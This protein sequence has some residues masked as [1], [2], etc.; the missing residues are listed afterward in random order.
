MGT[1][2]TFWLIP[3]CLLLCSGSGIIGL[4]SPSLFLRVPFLQMN[5]GYRSQ[6]FVRQTSLSRSLIKTP[7]KGNVVRG[8]GGTYPHSVNFTSDVTSLNDSTT[9][10]SCKEIP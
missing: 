5:G 7:M 1:I 4:Q 3:V 9:I 2:P 10:K 8:H 6:G